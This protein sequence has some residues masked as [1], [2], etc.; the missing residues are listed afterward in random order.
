MV[1]NLLPMD[2]TRNSATFGTCWPCGPLPRARSASYDKEANRA[3]K[4]ARERATESEAFLSLYGSRHH[5]HGARR[6]H[7][8][9]PTRI[10]TRQVPQCAYCS[11]RSVTRCEYPGC[12]VAMCA[13]CR[14]RKGGG[15]LCRDHR[16]ARLVQ[17]RGVPA[18]GAVPILAKIGKFRAKGP[19]FANPRG[20]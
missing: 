6:R 7:N 11:C 1:R 14:I 9:E 17:V 19:A 3:G 13:R 15:S 10:L 20:D 2:A 5:W 8:T 16:D 12:D 4:A 18:P